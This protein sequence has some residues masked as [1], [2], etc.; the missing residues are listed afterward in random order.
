MLEK[1]VYGFVPG[2]GGGGGGIECWPPVSSNEGVAVLSNP[3]TVHEVIAIKAKPNKAIIK[4]FFMILLLKIGHRFGY[5]AFEPKH[6]R[7]VRHGKKFIAM[8]GS[9]VC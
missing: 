2:G 5:S 4:Y 9:W 1:A 7:V 6:C 8:M 3:S